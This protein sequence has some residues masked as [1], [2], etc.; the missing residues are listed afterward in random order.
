MKA[1]VIMV[2]HRLYTTDALLAVLVHV[3]L[4]WLVG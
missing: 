4:T 3:G 1:L 2:I